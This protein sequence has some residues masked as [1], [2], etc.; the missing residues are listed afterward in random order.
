MACSEDIGVCG[1]GLLLVVTLFFLLLNGFVLHRFA[2]ALFL[3]FIL[4]LLRID[5]LI[6]GGVFGFS[7]G[8]HKVGLVMV[9]IR[10]WL[11]RVERL[12]QVGL[13]RSLVIEVV[14]LGLLVFV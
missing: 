4:V 8:S 1:A 6:L 12:T 10:T 7:A 9:A 5:I 2:G 3:L 14:K 13:N 11:L